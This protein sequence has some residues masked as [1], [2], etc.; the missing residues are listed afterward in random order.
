MYRDAS[1]KPW[2]SRRWAPPGYTR[3]ELEAEVQKPKRPAVDGK[4]TDLEK[5]SPGAGP[6]TRETGNGNAALGA[7][8]EHKEHY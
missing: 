4:E 1:A 3:E 6:S 5:R 8:E 7:E 2:T